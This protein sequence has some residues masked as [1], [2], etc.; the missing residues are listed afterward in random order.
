MSEDYGRIVV[1]NMLEHKSN[2]FVVRE[3]RVYDQ[4]KVIVKDNY[5]FFAMKQISKCD[6]RLLF[7]TCSFLGENIVP[8]YSYF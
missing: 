8:T 1:D 6:F 2:S 7:L 4:E 3:L 5:Y